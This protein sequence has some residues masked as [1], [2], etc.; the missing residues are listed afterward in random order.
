MKKLLFA[1]PV[2]LLVAAGCSSSQQT[3]QQN[4]P[5]QQTQT[6][7]PEQQ[8]TTQN[9][10]P[11]QTQTTPPPTQSQQN[12]QQ[13]SLTYNWNTQSNAVVNF[14][15]PTNWTVQKYSLGSNES[16]II[17]PSDQTV[18]LAPADYT[19]GLENLKHSVVLDISTGSCLNT[20]CLTKISSADDWI[21]ELGA[22]KLSKQLNVSGFTGYYVKVSGDNTYRYILSKNGVIVEMQTVSY[23]TYMNQVFNSLSISLNNSANSNLKTYAGSGIT[24]QYDP[25]AVAISTKGIKFI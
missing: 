22:T 16:I 23:V 24:F 5:T 1:L 10:T 17:Y 13:N 8:Q 2:I 15:Y 21:S 6:P 11:T 20:Q 18:N 3:S 7:T 25:Q 9:P 12:T 14:Q 4:L 19:A